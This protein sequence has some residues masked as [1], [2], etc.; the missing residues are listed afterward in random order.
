MRPFQVWVLS[1]VLIA[2]FSAGWFEAKSASFRLWRGSRAASG[3]ITRY[4]PYA[5]RVSYSYVVD[6]IRYEGRQTGWKANVGETVRVYYLPTRPAVST[7]TIP[8]AQLR[9]LVLIV[10][11]GAFAGASLFAWRVDQWQEDTR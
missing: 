10:L 7:L 4:E 3:V 8:G 2:A 11:V 5:A 6:G 9:S 1:F